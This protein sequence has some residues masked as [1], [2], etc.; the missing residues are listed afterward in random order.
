MIGG[1][2]LSDAYKRCMEEVFQVIR[3]RK[4]GVIGIDGAT[5]KLSKS[6]S[7]VILHTP[8]PLF[9]EYLKSDLKTDRA[10][11]VVSKI[12][13]VM[14]RLDDIIGFRAGFAFVS[15][16]CNK[17]RDIR[18]KLQNEKVFKWCYGCGSHALHNL[19]EDA[20]KLS[21][22]TKTVKEVVFV[23]KTI[24]YTGVIRRLFEKVCAKRRSRVTLPSLY[25]PTRWTSA[26]HMLDRLYSLRS[27]VVSLPIALLEEREN[28]RMDADYE[29]PPAFVE[30]I[31][32]SA[33][34]CSIQSTA[35]CFKFLAQA[36]T[37]LEAE[38][39]TLSDAYAAFLFVRQKLR[40]LSILSS[41]EREFLNR[42]L[43][44][45]WDRIYSPVHALAFACD[46]FYDQMRTSVTANH[47]IDFI[48]LGKGPLTQ[49]CIDAFRL[50][51][52]STEEQDVLLEELLRYGMDGSP[53]LSQLKPFHPT[54][55]WAQLR[56][57]YQKLGTLLVDVFRSPASTAG[58]ERNHK[59]GK[60]VLSQRRCRLGDPTIERQVGIAHNMFQLRKVVPGNTQRKYAALFTELFTQSSSTSNSVQLVE[61]LISNVNSDDTDTLPTPV[62][63]TDHPE[64]IPNYFLFSE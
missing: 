6:V 27:F 10:T 40:T 42:S 31:S 17:M 34:W 36:T 22:N 39:A 15:D 58:V 62:L 59:V 3:S 45:R 38:M 60:R 30:L 4:G 52:E 19:T 53:L 13:D 1:E 49:Q 48:G 33:F 7:N 63:N 9:I 25:S 18:T 57:E 2:L 44:R 50:L 55:V 8:V 16:S 32:S 21:N 41:A 61:E 54:L 47:G 56:A 51:S 64:D 20:G 5:N 11:N 12:K 35:E 23:S 26:S 14:K 37:I 43:L 46:P 24:K 28:Q 29:L